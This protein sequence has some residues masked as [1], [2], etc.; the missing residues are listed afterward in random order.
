MTTSANMQMQSHCDGSS[1]LPGIF[2]WLY[3]WQI[4]GGMRSVTVKGRE[5]QK[6]SATLNIYFSQLAV[7]LWKGKAL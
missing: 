4:L 2:L 6:S 5:K 3:P 1:G 7:T